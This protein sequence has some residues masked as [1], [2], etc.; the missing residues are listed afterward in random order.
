MCLLSVVLIDTYW[1]LLPHC[2]QLGFSWNKKSFRIHKSR[3][4]VADRSL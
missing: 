4:T 1:N 2:Y 3:N